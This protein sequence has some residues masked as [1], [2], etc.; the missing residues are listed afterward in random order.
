MS[1]PLKLAALRWSYPSIH[2]IRLQI[3][4]DTNEPQYGRY[5]FAVAKG[6]RNQIIA[7]T[8]GNCP[9]RGKWQIQNWMKGENPDDMHVGIDCSGFVYRVLDEA[10]QM[11]G[12]PSLVQTLG[13]TCEYT[14]LDTLTPRGLEIHRA[15]DVRAG[16]T[17]RF[18]K[19]KHSGVIIET[20]TNE[21]GLLTEIW[22]AH[23]SFTRGPHIGWIQVAD[24]WAPINHEVQQWHDEMWDWLGDNRLRDVYFT[25]VHHSPF[26]QGARPRVGRLTGVTIAVNGREIPFQVAPSVLGG[27]TLAQ[28]RPLAEGMGAVVDWNNDTQTVTMTKGSRQARCQ[29]G[30]EVGLIN[31]VGQL[32][33][34]PPV[35]VGEVVVVPV[36]F[37]AEG[38]GFQVQWDE[39]R[40]YVNMV[41]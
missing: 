26:Y 36:R 41:G 6:T 27:R 34:E 15:I 12:A 4:W 16:D 13:T 24:P 18:N 39:G 2:G 5:H 1:N 14:A 7:Y 25:S 21:H 22:Y 40:R 29:V 17:M 30:S 28:L 38:L 23:S 35:F 37:I 32:L 8:E 20:V 33:D 9:H 3:P 19:G 31:G 10:A 11:S